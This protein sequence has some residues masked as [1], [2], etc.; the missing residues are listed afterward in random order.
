MHK[1]PAHVRSREYLILQAPRVDGSDGKRGKHKGLIVLLSLLD[2]R[3]HTCAETL[4]PAGLYAAP[5]FLLPSAIPRAPPSPS[6]GGLE[7]A[8]AGAVAAAA[9]GSP[10]PAF[11]AAAS[12]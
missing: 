10:P 1:A 3:S 5:F 7:P 6:K 12:A 2:E 4:P 8:P 9:A 11:L